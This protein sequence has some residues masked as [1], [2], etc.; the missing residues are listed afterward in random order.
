MSPLYLVDGFNFLHAVLLEGRD[1][2]RWWSPENQAKVVAAVAQLSVEGRPLDAWVVFDR[3]SSAEAAGA[4]SGDLATP[5]GIVDPAVQIHHAPDADDY[6][7]R[8]CGELS[9]EREVVVVSADRSLC[10]RAKNRGARTLS[11]WAFAGYAAGAAGASARASP[12]NGMSNTPDEE[13]FMR[14]EVK[15][16]YLEKLA[17]DLEEVVI[18]Q[19]HVIDEL[20]GRLDRVERQLRAGEDDE[21]IP[22]EKPPH[23]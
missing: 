6:I 18:A 23:Y 5:A 13:R 12:R 20:K 10:D 8:W 15:A 19:G 1:R 4:V 17:L 2:A 21:R 14:L 9:A 7:V 22:D 3:R 11:P 16:A